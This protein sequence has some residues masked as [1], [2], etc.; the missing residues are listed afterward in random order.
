MKNILDRFIDGEIAVN[1]STEIQAIEFIELLYK[2]DIK[3][4][5]T[6]RMLTYWG[7]E[8]KLTCYRYGGSS[9]KY[10]SYNY[11]DKLGVGIVCY[12]DFIRKMKDERGIV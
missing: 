6:D 5:G 1:C 4:N 8:E 9:I 7:C 3:W 12:Y 2:N 11:Y 10:G